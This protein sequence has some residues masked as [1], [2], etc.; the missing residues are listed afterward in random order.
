MMGVQDHTGKDTVRFVWKE[1]ETRTDGGETGRNGA[2]EN[3]TEQNSVA[4]LCS[5][6][7]L[8]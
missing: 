2:G 6:M 4:G 5:C 8:G 7:L 3:K 1:S